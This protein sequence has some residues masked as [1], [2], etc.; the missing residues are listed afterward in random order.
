M[1][2]V[3]GS[4]T[5]LQDTDVDAFD[6][7]NYY[8]IYIYSNA[9][10]FSS[11]KYWSSVSGISYPYA[12]GENAGKYPNLNDKTTYPLGSATSIITTAEDYGESLD[13]TG[14][15]MTYEEANQLKISNSTIIY[16]QYESGKYLNYWLGSAYGSGGVWR[17]FGGEQQLG[18]QHM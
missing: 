10:A 7:D 1:K 15:L 6:S 8:S 5:L 13:A 11:T 2:K 3:S 4:L 18:R 14:R 16:G 12:S 9:C 17:V